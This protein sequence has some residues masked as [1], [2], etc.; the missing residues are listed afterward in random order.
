MEGKFKGP[1]TLSVPNRSNDG[2]SIKKAIFKI[3]IIV[4]KKQDK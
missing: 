2:E 1:G 3:A 4:H